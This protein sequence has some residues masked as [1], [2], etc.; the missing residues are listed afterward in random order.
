MYG[1]ERRRAILERAREDGRV[2]VAALAEE[3]DVTHETV[4]RD[5]T[6]L[7]RAGAVRRVH[8]GAIPIERIGFEPALP[9]RDALMAAEKDRIAEAALAELP[10]EGTVLLDA[11]STTRRL[12]ERLPPGRELTVVTN[13]LPI[14]ALVSSRP[15]ITPLLIGGRVRPRTQAAVGGWALRVLEEVYVDAAFLATNGVSAERG[16]TTP[17]TSEAEAKRRMVRAARR[18]VLLADRTKV[19]DDRFARFADLSEV[20]C[21]VTDAGLDARLAE[22]LGAAGPR[23]VLA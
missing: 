11:G 2:E 1:E 14:A 15:G 4:R 17:D 10:E 7:E 13:S 9:Q 6:A 8:G 5:L 22:E 20:D 16:L 23:V 19:G 12:A 18:V 21:L 3:F